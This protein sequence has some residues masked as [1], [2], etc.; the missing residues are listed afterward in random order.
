MPEEKDYLGKVFDTLK[1][2][3]DGFDKDE[4][5][6]RKAMSDT[7]YASKVHKTLFENIEGFNKTPEQFYEASGIVTEKKKPLPNTFRD[8]GI[9]L[10]KPSTQESGSSG[11]TK[12][13]EEF[14]AKY[15]TNYT[16][17]KT[18]QTKV[19]NAE[20]G[21]LVP[22]SPI[23]VKQPSGEKDFI[24]PK[25]QLPDLT[26]APM[27][28]Y[29]K[30]YNG[31]TGRIDNN[32]KEF[33][34]VTAEAEKQG[35]ELEGTVN[36][37]NN[38]LKQ[39]STVIQNELKAKYEGLLKAGSISAEDANLKL[40]EEYKKGYSIAEKQ[41]TSKYKPSLDS[42]TSL[43]DKRKTLGNSIKGD[44][45]RAKLLSNSVGIIERNVNAQNVSEYSNLEN[46]TV[47][48]LSMLGSA[49][50]G[51]LPFFLRFTNNNLAEYAAKNNM[52]E[53]VKVAFD[54][55]KSIDKSELLQK[56][57]AYAKEQAQKGSYYSNKI[58]EKEGTLV[59]NFS[60]GNYAQAGKVAS[61]RFL[62]SIPM[63]GAAI[64]MTAL[65]GGTASA[66][67]PGGF[68]FGSQNYYG[69]Y[70]DRPDMSETDKLNASFV[71]GSL[72]MITELSVMPLLSPLKG[73]IKTGGKEAV[74]E[75]VEKTLFSSMKEGYGKLVPYFG[76]VQEGLSEYA[77]EV[78]STITDKILDP[79][80]QDKD[81]GQV[82]KE[83][84]VRGLEA[85]GPGAFGG[86]TLTL[87]VAINNTI[88][89]YQN[90]KMAREFASELEKIEAD[91][92]NPNLTEAQKDILIAR[93]QEIHGKLNEVFDADKQE[94]AG[95]TT[96]QVSALDD[97]NDQQDEVAI[98]L[99]DETISDESKVAF[100]EKAKELA[101]QEK[102]VLEEI[103]A[104]EIVNEEE[105]N[106]AD[107][108]LSND[109]VEPI[110]EPSS[111][112]SSEVSAPNNVE[113]IRQLGTG[114]NVYFETEK[115]RVNDS[116]DGVILNIQNQSDEVPIANIKFDNANDAVVIAKEIE[117][118]FPKGVP[119]AILVE[120]YVDQ[121]KK[122]LLSPTTEKPKGETA[123]TVTT[124]ETKTDE[125]PVNEI[126]N[127]TNG[128]ELFNE[129][130]TFGINKSPDI[131]DIVMNTDV[132]FTTNNKGE[133]L[134]EGEGSLQE[135]RDII[136]ENP[137]NKVRLVEVR[138]DGDI[139]AVTIRVGG[140]ETIY[141]VD[142]KAVEELLA[143]EQT[144]NNKEQA[145]TPTNI[146]EN[147]NKEEKVENKEEPK[148][149]KR[150]RKNKVISKILD[151]VTVDPIDKVLQYFIGGGKINGDRKNTENAIQK[152][153]GKKGGAKDLDKTY[154][155]YFNLTRNNAPTLSE[156]AHSLWEENRDNSDY[157][158]Q[159]Y[160]EAIIEVLSTHNG[161]NSMK[162]AFNNKFQIDVS[163]EEIE[164][165]AADQAYID[166][167]EQRLN[168]QQQEQF[169]EE[170]ITQ[171]AIDEPLVFE[172]NDQEIEQVEELGIT[173]ETEELTAE[174]FEALEALLF[175][176]P[177]P[178][179]NNENGNEKEIKQGE[180]NVT[181]KQ[182]E[183]K[184][185]SRQDAE[186]KS[187][188]EAKVKEAKNAY[189]AAQSK[190]TKA[191]QAAE[192]AGQEQQANIFG[193]K[194]ADAL[195]F[196]TDLRSLNVK[197]K[198]RQAEADK[199]KE[200]LDKAQLALDSF[201][202]SNQV[203]LEVEA[204][205]EST[206]VKDPI[207][208]RLNKAFLKIGAEILDNA[209]Q[210]AAKAKELAS[211]GAKIDFSME[212]AIIQSE[213]VKLEYNSNG[214]HLAPNGKPSNLTEQQAK[215]V[216]TP[217][218]KKWF[219][220]WEND[221]KNASKIVDKNGEP[222]V[223][224]HGT[225]STITEFDKNT[226]GSNT[227][228]SSAEKGFFV[229]DTKSIAE[230]YRRAVQV[231]NPNLE[232]L[233]TILSE[234]S[235]EELK[236][237]G[238]GVMG[239]DIR[240]FEKGDYTKEEI[241]YELF[242]DIEN[243]SE[244]YYADRRKLIEKASKYLKENKIE[245]SPYQNTGML[246]EGFLNIRNPKK[247]DAES[248]TAFDIDLPGIID[249]SV[250]ENKDGV[251]VENVYDSV[252]FT[253]KGTDTEEGSIM[254]F[255]EPN[256]IKLADGTN[257]TFDSKVNDF[258]Y[259]ITLPNGSQKQVKAIDVDVVNGFYSPLEKVI[260]EA[261]Q[262][263]MPAKQWAEKFAKGEEAKW[264]GLQDWLAQQQGSVS[265]TDIQ[266]FLKENRI[267]VVEVVKSDNADSYSMDRYEEFPQEVKNI[268][269]EFGEDEDEFTRQL[270]AIG[271][272]VNRDM[273]GSILSFNKK[274]EENKFDKA[275]KFSQYQLEGE[276]EN[277]KEVLVTMPI[278]KSKQEYVVEQDYRIPN[279][280]Y[281]VNQKTGVKLKFGSYEL[282]KSQAE[283]LSKEAQPDFDKQF[284]SSHFDEPNILVHLRMNTRVDSEGN[285][286]LFLEEIQ[287]DWGQ[288]GKK[289]GFA[290]TNAEKRKKELL[291]KDELTKS[292]LNELD[293]LNKE[294]GFDTK[295]PA[296]PFV[297]DTN[298]WTKLGLKVAL[299]E[300]VKQGA[301][302]I[303]WTTGEQQNERYD[304]SKSIEVVYATKGD[305]KGKLGEYFIE[306][307]PKDGG[308]P[309]IA[310]WVKEEKL[311]SIIGKD[312]AEKIISNNGGE[313]RGDNLK[314]GGKGMKGFYGS[315]T[316]GSLGIVGNVAKSLFK[317]E[318]K[319]IGIVVNSNAKVKMPNEE[320]TIEKVN[321]RNGWLVFN[322][323]EGEDYS[324]NT[325]KEADKYI[326]ELKLKE[327]EKSVSTQ[328]SIDITPELA[329]T[330]EQGQPLFHLN[331]KGEI[332][333]FTY[334]GKIY[335]NGE[336]I[337]A[338]TTM[339]EAG[340]IWINWAKENRSDLYQQGLEKVQ[341]SKYLIEVN[342][343]P[344][345]QKE[346]LKQGE[347]GSD[348]YNAYM[349]E[350]ALAKAIADNGAKFISETRKASFREWVNAMWKEVAKAFG[351]QNLNPSEVKALTLEE[352][353]RMAAA[354]VFSSK[355]TPVQEQA[356]EKVEDAKLTDLENEV[357]EN[358]LSKG[359]G[360]A[361]P[362]SKV[363]N[364]DYPNLIGNDL[365]YIDSWG[366]GKTVSLKL[367]P[368]GE[369]VALK[370]QLKKA[371]LTDSKRKIQE[372]I[373]ELEGNEPKVPKGPS[374]GLGSTTAANTN[375]ITPTQNAERVSMKFHLELKKLIESIGV[376]IAERNLSKRF[377]G[378]FK[379][380]GM[381]IRVQSLFGVATAA[382]ETAHWVS[383]KFGIG[384]A[385][386][387][388]SAVVAANP[389]AQL[390]K[391]IRKALTDIYTEFY[392]NAKKEHSLYLRVEEGIAVLMEHY[393]TDPT[394]ITNRYG[395][396]VDNFIAP[397]GKYYHPKFTELLDKLNKFL[398]EYSA[399][400]PNEKIGSRIVSGEE[401]TK[402]NEGFT[403]KQAV[404]RG[405]VN[406][407]EPLRRADNIADAG[408]TEE[409]TEVAYIR[410][411]SRAGI[412]APWIT[413]E[414]HPITLDRN[415]NWKEVGASVKDYLEL[416]KG[417]E[418]E[419]SQYLVARRNLGDVN[420]LTEM[421]N[422]LAEI[423]ANIENEEDL[424]KEEVEEINEL[425]ARIEKQKQIIKNDN[426]DIQQV[427]ATV[428]MFEDKFKAPVAIY[429]KLNNAAVDFAQKSGLISSETAEAYKA[430][431]T[432]TSFKRQ[433]MDDI[434]SNV[435]AP[436]TSS[437]S[438]VSAFKERKGSDLAI[439]DPVYSQIQ[440]ITETLNKGMQNMIW[441][442][443]AALGN[444]NVELARRFEKV[445]TIRVVDP[446]SGKITYPQMGKPGLIMVKT[447]GKPSFY[448]AAPEYVA[449]A[450]T[451]TPKELET[452]AYILTKSAGIF[453]RLTTSA[454]P[455][456]P[457]VNIPI[458]TMSA[459]MNT[460]TGF[461]PGWSQMRAIPEMASYAKDK[462]L[463]SVKNL[464]NT[465]IDFL[466]N[467]II[468]GDW[469]K[470]IK[471]IPIKNLSLEEQNLFAKYLALGG[472]TQ[473]LSS[474]LDMSPEE[475]IKAITEKSLAKK[476]A[477]HID[478]FTLGILE[479]PSNASEYMTRFA[480][481]KR[482]K[483]Q[484][485]SDD[486]AMYMAAH[487]S[488]PFIQSGTYG[489][490]VG[491]TTV[492]AVP[493]FHAGIQ[494]ISKFAQTA[495]NNPTRTATI[496]AAL[497]AIKIS[498]TLLTMA[499]SDDDDKRMLAEQEPSELGKY[500]YVPN[501]LFGGKGF[502]RIRFGNEFGTISAPIEMMIL[503]N[504]GLA[505]YNYKDYL[506]ATTTAIP[507]QF[508]IFKPIEALWA[509][510][511][512]IVRPSLEVGFN[513]RTYPNVRPIV[514]YGVSFK[515]PMNQYNQYTTE[516]SKYL[517][518]LAGVSPMKID[519]F[520]KAQFGKV[521]DMLLRKTEEIVVG[522]ENK[523]KSQ[524]F[525]QEEQY[526]L[527]G[528]NYTDFYENNKYWDELYND[529]KSIRKSGVDLNKEQLEVIE[530]HKIFNN[531]ESIIKKMRDKVNENIELPEYLKQSAFE[532][533][534]DLNNSDKPYTFVDKY[535]KLKN[536][537]LKAFPNN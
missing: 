527:A 251:W 340:H 278:A 222:M 120:K 523:S 40:Q 453:S 439:I 236:Q 488:V 452:M 36:K 165:E 521:P 247:I 190:L 205:S 239:Y 34:K 296:A 474:Y 400:S 258:R 516:T 185:S 506:D 30:A 358:V 425:S 493:Y 200:N 330:V 95:A 54:N 428:R 162:E 451:L 390:N 188:L 153:F 15:G 279:T 532:L 307:T 504:K 386:R 490:Q 402:K 91:I 454:N 337:T 406:A 31:I 482:A 186:R 491:K 503:Q 384:E 409:S 375:N 366:S 295:T 225:G 355:E 121:L 531:T 334:N 283:R 9:S 288:Q 266:N 176:E 116:K 209:E 232:G 208:K 2:T 219:G 381:N 292:E 426:F 44:V 466:H 405:L 237:F 119:D 432:Y 259:N 240:T 436:G 67:I 511:P 404:I 331:D 130:K 201:V 446:I 367:T 528:K 191:K 285:K 269:E 499:L 128:L 86:V 231:E 55:Q 399:L 417:R 198:E 305:E 1:E 76:W 354:D 284:K 43:L 324:F 100:E 475:M 338:K 519:Y 268:A 156:L 276:K 535:T 403:P 300:A 365:V 133:K 414:T 507:Q 297:T 212:Q 465:A 189:Q 385:L 411:L 362:S 215:I 311:E 479:M 32:T 255:F 214:K 107:N 147:P 92:Q 71:K 348:A 518:K 14:N 12:T 24:A 27:K 203:Q 332:L 149:K 537:Y 253:E 254:V 393:L 213:N 23:K 329:A 444:N 143:K 196:G 448:L 272:Q 395:I 64:G 141:K 501:K 413:G 333:G 245:F 271:Y 135:L 183:S 45:E 195:L 221:P 113:P 360:L 154:K 418:A 301:T 396:L 407:A 57:E 211:G 534:I 433:I 326:S 155:S 70:A 291:A 257:T 84:N 303:A 480:E 327:N 293:S 261:K 77:N 476:V 443:L 210:L 126:K 371:K 510:T 469:F 478:D 512:Q 21:V 427:T 82:I 486:V 363:A 178:I 380:R 62:E 4:A 282:A 98:A 8:A 485:Y 477:Q 142:T 419:F 460:K 525:L 168:E 164:R 157:T 17:L 234:L 314:V 256:Q 496:G 37:Y 19:D 171:E 309:A 61:L 122:E 63:M 318:P 139:T 159:D 335:L 28:R 423:L 42:Y 20:K 457:L 79:K 80:F 398:A 336:K 117:S 69:E 181:P 167:Q 471:N 249:N 7:S 438:K 382:H 5:T 441:Q 422:E 342:N 152:I 287:S 235:V 132:L 352:F 13:V 96:E 520:I 265:K 502:T 94:T 131:T 246:I 322:P 41:I 151:E 458:D 35:K 277:Y 529:T 25:V 18:G 49:M 169:N 440:F 341:G 129:A 370:E 88:N 16:D 134:Q 489:G 317:Q 105:P 66:I 187:A 90:K 173:E 115:Y 194:P 364:S 294:L 376:P 47:S 56:M 412:I 421:E 313:F 526:V 304:L 270:E 87:P 316:E 320:A 522:K 343:N 401:V 140:Q 10:A 357:W 420:Y 410:W 467:M 524:I 392:P 48:G 93:K 227:G 391:D 172:L 281:A 220:D 182:S 26:K 125:S 397:T 175:G 464:A 447:N 298:A 484:G 498:Q 424:T 252:S 290:T 11:K 369:L 310:E 394:D 356:V 517:G 118:K 104:N 136:K 472:S 89:K 161:T 353:A 145:K 450:E 312:L 238:K 106:T 351:I 388:K 280:F 83:A 114:A 509:Y 416:I 68:M 299:K 230:S 515:S 346:A 60:Q 274:G 264:T 180:D 315:P 431:T 103:K 347:K 415:G 500:I 229:S 434:A 323:F 374:D 306:A 124:K 202:P 223:V 85:F 462:A 302:K 59:D 373:D 204:P 308:P 442:K 463:L 46:L 368:K 160:E 461:I 216:R 530:N 33:D 328:Y 218:F 262:D 207:L 372:R 389:D 81:W 275:T 408:L 494:V 3:V 199:A 101:E 325:E 193:G 179:N 58:T 102:A 112:S 513:V 177:Q 508:N 226:R 497:I 50:S 206:I 75:A 514:P 267:E 127:G 242:R 197:V 263:K 29:E 495:K 123:E 455:L 72:E 184:E 53:L 383:K 459:W 174:Q 6:F 445:E 74:R 52:P 481:F 430:N 170:L 166:E 456:F 243:D 492:K 163:A 144:P 138:K 361:L 387:E 437:Q 339:E 22:F 350:E 110:V 241:E 289:L 449:L 111:I 248:Q 286:V 192:K 468:I 217:A 379:H 65:T 97:I 344:S 377:L 158:S 224:Y 99:Q 533:L 505:K 470:G 148:K 250:S 73:L 109:V 51:S 108:G 345:Y 146:K 260:S 321:S 273:D 228:A 483:D 473:T 349:Q 359:Q 39:A 536:N 38:E 429:D 233:K 78:G 378:I 244:G 150:V 137:K 435:L 487:V 319:T